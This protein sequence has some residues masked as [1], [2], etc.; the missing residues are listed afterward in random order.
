MAFK[1]ERQLAGQSNAPEM[2]IEL[3]YGSSSSATFKAG[4]AVRLNSG[5]VTKCSG[6]VKGE[7]IVAQDVS[8][9]AATDK[10]KVYKVLPTMV[11]EVPLS[12]YSATYDKVGAR[13]TFYS[14]GAKVTAT[15]AT[16]DGAYIVDTKGAK[17]AGDKVLVMMGYGVY[18]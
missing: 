8:V 7:F 4:T 5:V 15:A 2:F 12:A 18:A 10:I 1:L 13:V 9:A 14:D 6:D 16:N 11:F 17:A 3:P